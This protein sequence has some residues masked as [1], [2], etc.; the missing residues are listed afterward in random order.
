[1]TIS[2][3]THLRTSIVWCRWEITLEQLVR[4]CMHNCYLFHIY[5]TYCVLFL[6]CLPCIQYESIWYNLT[7]CHWLHYH[8]NLDF[9][10]CYLLFTEFDF[11]DV[12]YPSFRLFFILNS[13]KDG[14]GRVHCLHLLYHKSCEPRGDCYVGH[15]RM[16]LI[17][18]MSVSIE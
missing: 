8:S 4:I 5:D 14:N 10:I 18:I 12:S 11:S 9:L 2:R 3:S 16:H 7:Y 13:G 15:F 1:M 17:V 6:R